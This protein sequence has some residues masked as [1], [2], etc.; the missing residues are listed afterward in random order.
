M[1]NKTH[2][3]VEITA[4]MHIPYSI[5][6]NVPSDISNDDVWALLVRE[7]H[8]DG[9]AMKRD[10]CNGWGGEWTWDDVY[11]SDFNPDADDYSEYFE[12]DS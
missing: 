12:D 7:G 10:D 4:E 2:R 1:D 11:D 3:T 9:G 5:V 6:I 8:I